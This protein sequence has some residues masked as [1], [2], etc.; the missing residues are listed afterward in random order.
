MLKAELCLETVVDTSETGLP[1]ASF[2]V[3]LDVL[4]SKL[5]GLTFVPMLPSRSHSSSQ[6]T[7]FESL[8][9]ASSMCTWLSPSVFLYLCSQRNVLNIEREAYSL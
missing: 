5:E 4:P 1:D 3:S 8:S 7:F 9:R 6:A 2:P